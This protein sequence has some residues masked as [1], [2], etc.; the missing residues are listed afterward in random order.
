MLKSTNFKN[1]EL[2][3]RQKEIAAEW[4]NIEY[5]LQDDEFWLF[6]HDPN[7]DKPTR[8]EFIFN[9]M[10]EENKL[11]LSSEQQKLLGND[12]HKTFRYFYEY[13]N[14]KGSVIDCWAKVKEYFQTLNEW[15]NNITFY[16]YVGFLIIYG[17]SVQKLLKMWQEAKSRSAFTA[18]L[19][20]EINN[21]IPHDALENKDAIDKQKCK[22]LL[23][24]HNIQTVINQN[25][26]K[27]NNENYRL[28]V[29]YK[30]P[31]HLYKKEGWDVEHINSNTT[32]PEADDDTKN[33]WLVNVYIPAP[34][35]VQGMIVNY[36]KLQDEDKKK[37]EFEKIKQQLPPQPEE[38]DDEEKN[39]LWNYALLDFHTNRSYGNAIFSAKRRIIISKDQGKNLEIPMLKKSDGKLYIEDV[40]DAPVTSPFVP[41]CTK[42]VFLKYYSP[43]QNDNNYWTKT[44]AEAYLK[45][46]ENCVEQLKKN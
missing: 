27:Q 43:T 44:D 8:I 19:K 14:A 23:L 34:K 5:T 31:F 4:D 17:S 41:P 26:A 46:I 1:T 10:R 42:H 29:F 36:F 28:G 15:F 18:K 13:F 9:L 33:E 25:S 20:N 3:L 11:S 2:E 30:F 24:F 22:P 38:W 16:H 39:R 40:Q 6:I 45:D 12:E 32:N 37:E 21:K 7:Y 35:D